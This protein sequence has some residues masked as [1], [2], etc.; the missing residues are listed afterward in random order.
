MHQ[1][2][3]T[4]LGAVLAGALPAMATPLQNRLE[5]LSTIQL[6]QRLAEINSELDQLARYNPRGGTGSIGYRS[7]EY[8]HA[9][10]TEWVQVELEQPTQID[11]IILVPAIS[12]NVESGFKEDGFPMNFRIL[13]GAGADTQGTVIASFSEKD[14]LL[15]R[16]APLVVSCKITASWV[17]VEASKLSSRQF[18]GKFNLEL[19]ELLIFDGSENVALNRPITLSTPDRYREIF[20]RS[21]EYL[22]D[23]FMPYQM[24]SGEGEKGLAFFNAVI[25]NNQPSLTIDLEAA[26]PL[27]RIYLHTVDVSDTAPQS[28]PSGHALPKH[29]LV[30]GANQ[31][32][33]SDA[34][35]LVDYKKNS[36]Y[37]VGPIIARRFPET[38]CRYVRLTALEPYTIYQNGKDRI[39]M[40]FAEIELFAGGENL[41]LRKPV[42]TQHLSTARPSSLLV[43]G[44][45]IYGRILSTREWMAQ[46]ARRHELENERPLIAVELNSRYTRQTTNIQRLSWLCAI[47]VAGT[48]I[49]V[50]VDR[51]IRLR[52]IHRTRERIAADLHDELG[53]NLHAIG[54]LSD[55]VSR[56]KENPALLETLMPRMRTLTERTA[57]AAKYCTNMLEAEG[58]YDDLTEDM[59]RTATRI[60]SDH[61]HD[62]SFKGEELTQNIP[63][64]K[65]I[66]LFLFYQECLTNIIRHAEAT[67]IK[68]RFIASDTQ[69]TLTVTDN[70]HGLN[71]KKPSSLKRRARLLGGRLSTESLQ[72]SGTQITLRLKI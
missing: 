11:Q 33:F 58:L 41:A 28:I 67:Q 12:R 66:D 46:L 71:G 17:R 37:D 61:E 2:F 8:L 26:Y 43:D 32:D 36:I 55:Y 25:K 59:R 65:R 1:I 39:R 31:A 53:A 29:L 23:G 9:D 35:P 49:I 15:P 21:K 24:D 27:S 18:D 69:L 6:E 40:G 14:Q 56:E 34:V 22:V 57:A 54:L 13:A 3:T 47:L 4:L 72:N 42:K 5:N 7:P 38:R 68:T 52:A 16:I 20:A 44:R 70:G 50:L 19:A 62:I 45:N 64:R 48:I 51:M 30:E 63:P 10:H 60:T